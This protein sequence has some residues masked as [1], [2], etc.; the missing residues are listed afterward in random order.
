VSIEG[1]AEALFS[2]PAARAD[3]LGEMLALEAIL[4]PFRAVARVEQ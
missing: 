4:F 1:G 3:S 2:H